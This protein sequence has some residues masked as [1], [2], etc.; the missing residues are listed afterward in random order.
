VSFLKDEELAQ[1]NGNIVGY[2]LFNQYFHIFN[3]ISSFKTWFV[4]SIL[5]F[6]KW[7]DADILAFFMLATVLAT[8]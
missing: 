4:A 5:R 7:F 8:F 3:S 6:Q 2:F 1:R